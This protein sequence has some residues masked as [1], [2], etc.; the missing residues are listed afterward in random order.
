M[1]KLGEYIGYMVI[2]VL[3]E[4]NKVWKQYNKNKDKFIKSVMGRDVKRL[5]LDDK[6]KNL[7]KHKHFRFCKTR[8]EQILC[9]MDLFPTLTSQEHSNIVDKYRLLSRLKELDALDVK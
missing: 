5:S 1:S 8:N 2:K 7:P 9:S 3:P 4:S 6:A